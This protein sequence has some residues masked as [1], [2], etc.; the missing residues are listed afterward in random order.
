MKEETIKYRDAFPK[1]YTAPPKRP[2]V[3]LTD[4][5]ADDLFV[6]TQRH[7]IG[8]GSREFTRIFTHLINAKLKEKN[9]A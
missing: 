4:A 6:E 9:C 1:E 7:M 2:W 3:D 5:D 8:H